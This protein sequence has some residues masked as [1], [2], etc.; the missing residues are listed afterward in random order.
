MEINASFS[1]SGSY[2]TVLDFL[3]NKAIEEQSV[4][5]TDCIYFFDNNQILARSWRVKFNS[6]PLISVITT[7]VCLK[8][9]NVS[10]LQNC[11]EYSPRNWLSYASNDDAEHVID[12]TGAT[13]RGYRNVFITNEIKKLT[14]NNQSSNHPLKMGKIEF[15]SGKPNC[16]PQDPSDPYSDIESFVTGETTVV[17]LDP[18]MVNPC[19][20]QSLVT[21]LDNILEK[22]TTKW[23]AIGCDGLP[24]NLCS[25]MIDNYYKCPHC[26]ETYTNI[27]AFQHHLQQLDIICE[28]KECRK[29][30]NI[31]LLPGFGHFDINITKA[32]FKLL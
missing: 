17:L 20:Y 19:S 2:A 10:T 15:E 32:L 16:C 5:N 18:V 6:K 14:D 27:L 9:P 3:K 11:D 13:F 25:K 22:S 4:P 7:I 29:Y 23:V 30:H 26:S 8:P 28:R 12:E 31:L 21:V 24:Y 1:P